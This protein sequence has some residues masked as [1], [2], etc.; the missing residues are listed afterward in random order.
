MTT[1]GWFYGFK[2][3]LVINDIGEIITFRITHGATDDREPLKSDAF[4]NKLFGKLV[5]D[6]GYISQDLFERLFVDDIHM[7]TKRK[8]NMKNPLMHLHDKILLRKRALIE[9]GNDQLKNIAQSNIPDIV[10]YTTFAP[11][12][13]Q[14]SLLT[15]P[16]RRSLH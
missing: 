13:L 2:L 12:Y 7:I 4:T 5:A 11:I 1:L 3:H 6:R 14:D 8:R 9:S 15:N 10:P 16:W